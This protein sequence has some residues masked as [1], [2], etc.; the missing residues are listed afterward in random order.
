MST[1]AR[2]FKPAVKKEMPMTS[3]PPPVPTDSKFFQGVLPGQAMRPPPSMLPPGMNIT[4][5]GNGLKFP[6][7]MP[8]GLQKMFQKA[9]DDGKFD[10]LIMKAMYETSNKESEDDPSALTAEE[11][12]FASEFFADQE[13]QTVDICPYYLN[14]T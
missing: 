13:E 2:E 1:K 3:M 14:G 8:M 4:F 11:E 9:Y 7:G 5:D 6:P 12:A 10:E